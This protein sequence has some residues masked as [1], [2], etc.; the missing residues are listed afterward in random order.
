[1]RAETPCTLLACA[2]SVTNWKAQTP[3]AIDDI[4]P[5]IDKAFDGVIFI[6]LGPPG[7]GPKTKLEEDLLL[8]AQDNV[9]ELKAVRLVSKHPHTLANLRA[10]AA[11]QCPSVRN[12]PSHPYNTSRNFRALC[13][14]NGP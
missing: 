2:R 7:Q 12:A 5:A 1:M 6:K 9:H 10:A 4:R 14:S 8:A 11:N 3:Y 13:C